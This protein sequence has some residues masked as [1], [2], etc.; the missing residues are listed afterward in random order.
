MG[1]MG[2]HLLPSSLDVFRS[3]YPSHLRYYFCILGILFDVVYTGFLFISLLRSLNLRF[4]CTI[5]FLFCFLV[6]K[7]IGLLSIVVV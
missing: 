4:L 7:V 1:V 5:W 6:S 3:M 2:I